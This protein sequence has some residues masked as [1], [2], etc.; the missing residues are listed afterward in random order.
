MIWAECLHRRIALIFVSA[1]DC[2]KHEGV[3]YLEGIC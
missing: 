2:D 3:A 1:E